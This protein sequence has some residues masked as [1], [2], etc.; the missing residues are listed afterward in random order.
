MPRTAHQA[1]ARDGTQLHWTSIG[2]GAPTIVLTDG[3]GCAGFVWRHLEPALARQHRVLHWNYRGHGKS[4]TPREAF[5]VTVDDCAEDL[6]AV[7]DAAGEERAVLVGHSMGVQVVLEAHRRAPERIQALVLVCGAPGRPIDTFHDSPALKLAFPFARSA[8]EKHPL[9][10]RVLFKSIIPTD[11]AVEFALNFEVD[12]ARVDRADLVRYFEELSAVDPLLF[13]RMLASAGEHDSLDHLGEVDAPTLIVAG[14]RDS[15]TP[16]RLSGAMHRA[17]PGSE[18][19]VLAGGSHVAPLECPGA[20]TEQVEGFLSRA[21]APR[22]EPPRRGRGR[23]PARRTA[24][25]S[26]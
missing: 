25:K 7:L 3:V 9:L 26:R 1:I 4:G 6:L 12:R 13:V 10:A 16:M 14:E 11:F 19:H 24:R 2:E 21:L 17:I 23:A 8:V 18:L 5:R 20:L 22:A 15:F